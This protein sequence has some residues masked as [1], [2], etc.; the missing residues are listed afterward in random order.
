M[1]QRRC[2]G[3][4]LE[5]DK[6]TGFLKGQSRCKTCRNAAYRAAYS[7]GGAPFQ[8][9]AVERVRRHRQAHGR[10]DHGRRRARLHQSPAEAFTRRDLWDSYAEREL[11]ACVYCGGPYAHDDHA[12]PL[13]RGGAHAIGNLVPACAPCNLEK[14]TRTP[15]E[16]MRQL[17]GG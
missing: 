16:Y 17:H 14:H 15:V 2:S 10:L 7:A 8:A 1:S 6:D 13:A 4:G 5:H 9:A 3:C 11:F 12:R